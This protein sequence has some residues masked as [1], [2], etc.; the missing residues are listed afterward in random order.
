MRE[1]AESE[2]VIPDGQFKG[3]RFRCDR[4]PFTGLLFDEIDSGRWNRFVTTGP[5]QSGKSLSAYIIPMM[6]HVFE[7]GETVIAGIPDMDMA[8]DKWREDIEP[9]I[10]ASRY[11]DL[12]PTTGGGSRGGRVEAI[13]FKH[14]PT[15]KFMSGGGSD[16]S[17][18]G[19]TARVVVITETDGMDEPGGASREADK[20]SQLEARTMSYDEAKRIYMECTVS[21][22]EGRTWSEIKGGS[23]SRLVC[24]CPHCRH[25]VT[26]EREDLTG[27]QAAASE[28]EAEIM[29]AYVCPNCKH[30][31]TAEERAAMNRAAR[32]LHK[33]QE[34][35]PRGKVTGELPKT[36]TLGFRWNAFNNLFMRAGTVGAKEWARLNEEDEARKTNMEKEL[37]QFFWAKAYKP[38]VVETAP[39]TLEGLRS[40]IVAPGR[41]IVPTAARL[42]TMG[43]DI[44]KFL[45][46]YALPA[47][48]PGA[49]GHVTDYGVIEVP[50]VGLGVERGIMNA[51]LQLAEMVK[52]GWAK[53]EGGVVH[54]LAVF[55]DS[56]YHPEIIYE[57]CR[58][59]GRP[60]YPVKGFGAG[61][62]RK[63]YLQPRDTGK[64][65]R[66]VGDEYHFVRLA[67]E[68][69]DLCH[70]NADH[71]KTW[72]HQ[73]LMT[74]I[75]Q[76]GAMTLFHLPQ[77]EHTTFIQ[78]LKA[79]VQE[80]EWQPGK[81]IIRRWVRR[82]QHNH[83]FDAI[84]MAAA[85]A[86]F[87]GL[88]IIAATQRAAPI[89]TG[90]GAST[91]T[92]VLPPDRFGRRFNR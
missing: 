38:Q 67:K 19:F 57:F 83:Y 25:W 24:K 69:I 53:K 92:R 86:H 35:T 13:K 46:H 32:V 54:P 4:Q 10:A 30:E 88:R 11:R 43:V 12:M 62:D 5:T 76:P 44:G 29:S 80:E 26:P 82:G 27:Y 77:K 16:K 34:I 28:L 45:A 41:G 61:Q 3:R 84:Y 1:F 7:I 64:V 20:I 68:Q 56:G 91:K 59:H 85:A 18:A 55:I 70:I 2:I 17:R 52:A 89:S 6:Y 22:E 78:H 51:L 79:E 58:T 73:R 50:S 49:N 74:P 72:V 60:F 65:V 9:A 40:R 71:W 14:G 37:K 39:L 21:I 15:L 75:E 63:S 47:W 66:F 36:R 8:G 48:T 31:I 33:G 87:C 42:V 90:S 81:G 23:D